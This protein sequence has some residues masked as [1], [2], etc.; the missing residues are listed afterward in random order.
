MWESDKAVSR[1]VVYSRH[2][3]ERERERGN[4]KLGR[5]SKKKTVVIPQSFLSL[6]SHTHTK[7]YVCE[8][9][10]NIIHVII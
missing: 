7:I 9:P 3:R 10:Y 6:Y 5:M 1:G 2:E 8:P 4:R